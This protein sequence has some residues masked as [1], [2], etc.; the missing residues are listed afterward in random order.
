MAFYGHVKRKELGRRANQILTSLENKK[1]SIMDERRPSASKKMRARKRKYGKQVFRKII[2][3]TEEKN[4]SDSKPTR[5]KSTFSK[6]QRSRAR[7]AENE[8]R[9]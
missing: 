7:E 6:V 5:S 4:L 3:V 1:I 2:R 9:R 8:A